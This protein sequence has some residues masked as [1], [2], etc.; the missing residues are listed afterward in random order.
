MCVGTPGAAIVTNLAAGAPIPEL[1]DSVC[2]GDV[3]LVGDGL[4][5]HPWYRANPEQDQPAAGSR[6]SCCAGSAR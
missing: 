3:Y 1:P 2:E 5:A 4:H 6:W